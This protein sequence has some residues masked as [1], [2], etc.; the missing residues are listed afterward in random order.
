MKRSIFLLLTCAPTGPVQSALSRR[1]AVAWR[2]L[3]S[4]CAME[5]GGRRAKGGA[6]GGGGSSLG[7]LTAG[8]AD[9][10]VAPADKMAATPV[11]GAGRPRAQEQ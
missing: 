1:T 10:T 5:C 4:F 2:N 8:P 11:R 7:R 3:V 9:C 6:S